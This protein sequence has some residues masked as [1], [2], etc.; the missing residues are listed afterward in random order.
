MRR[1]G[2]VQVGVPGEAPRTESERTRGVERVAF[3]PAGKVWFGFTSGSLGRW[4]T[5]D[6]LGWR[7]FSGGRSRP[8]EL[9]AG[10]ETREVSAWFADGTFFE[11]RLETE[12]QAKLEVVRSWRAREIAHV[13]TAVAE[14]PAHD[15]TVMAGSAGELSVRRTST[16][17]LVRVLSSDGGAVSAIAIDER[18]ER[19]VAGGRD[20]CVHLHELGNPS[21]SF[22]LGQLDE[23]VAGVLFCASGAAVAAISEGG[24]LVRWPATVRGGLV[25]LRGHLLPVSDA[26]LSEDGAHV[27]TVGEDRLVLVF[28]ALS[29]CLVDA[30]SPREL[31]ATPWTVRLDAEASEARVADSEGGVVAIQVPWPEADSDSSNRQP[32]REARIG[33]GGLVELRESPSDDEPVLGLV[34]EGVTPRAVS[35]AAGRVLVAGS[36]SG[37]VLLD[38]VTAQER[39]AATVAPGPA[40]PDPASVLYAALLP[41]AID[42]ADRSGPPRLD[43]ELVRDLDRALPRDGRFQFLFALDQIRRGSYTSARV[44]LRGLNAQAADQDVGVAAE[45][46]AAATAFVETTSGGAASAIPWLARAAGSD[47]QALAARRTSQR[48]A[49][50]IGR[51]PWAIVAEVVA[52]SASTLLAP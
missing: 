13:V 51:R 47:L 48:I 12:R 14:S 19:V 42:H 23:P 20:G 34:V 46:L 9:R 28:D 38:T 10:T 4:L 30:R 17:E 37:V 18:G 3:D 39:F 31:G 40:R 45:D 7:L 26:A 25:E 29:G 33:V 22:M 43:P 35:A 50:R 44:R 8:V 6:P 21:G 2:R 16:G 27:V 41:P 49:E 5:G 11:W 52:T 1:D 24:D 32:A 36:G 15:L